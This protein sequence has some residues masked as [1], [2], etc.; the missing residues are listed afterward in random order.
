MCVCP[1]FICPY[2]CLPKK[3]NSGVMDDIADLSIDTD[4]TLRTLNSK[5]VRHTILNVCI[6][7][8]DKGVKMIL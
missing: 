2:E 7:S 8:Y 3:V 4:T 1:V 5:H 6:L